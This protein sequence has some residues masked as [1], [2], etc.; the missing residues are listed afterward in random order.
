MN[1]W[2]KYLSNN[3]TILD[4]AAMLDFGVTNALAYCTE[5]TWT[6]LKI[7]TLGPGACSL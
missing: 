1:N 5:T 6:N 2:N 7:M 4:T 3:H